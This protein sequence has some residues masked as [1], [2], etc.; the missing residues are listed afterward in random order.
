MRVLVTGATGFVGAH[1]V[2][3]LDAAGH[4]VRVLAR[5]PARVPAALGPFG[6]EP[7]VVEGDMTD[8]A[9]VASAVEGCDAVLHLA[10]QIGVGGGA[11][12]SDANLTGARTVIDAAVAAGVARIVYTSSV[13]VH[14][15]TDDPVIT[16]DTPLATPMSTYAESKVAIETY[17]RER[18]D[19][20]HPITSVVL[21]GVYGPQSLEL[22]SSFSAITSALE[23]M[24]VTPPGG[25]TVVDVRDVARLLTRIVER[26]EPVRRV[27]AGG[28][29]VSWDAWVDALE[30]AW[31][32]PVGRLPIDADGLVAMARDLEAAAPPGE[33]PV[34]DV[35]AAIVMT[36]GVPLADDEWFDHY[37][38]ERTPIEVTFADAVRFLRSVGRLPDVASG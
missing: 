21:G 1:T 10:A 18:Q 14:M 36:T 20:G 17:V 33:P 38:V 7:M 25:T 9:A 4:D 5:T 2:A 15:P 35:E 23:S 8:A 13:T 11:A 16:L 6:V 34:L 37:G 32:A 3:A 24:M 22:Q 27:L 30:A 29:F 19:E 28:H 12:A 26:N 31:G